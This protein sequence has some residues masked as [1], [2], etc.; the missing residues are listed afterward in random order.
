MEKQLTKEEFQ[1]VDALDAKQ[2]RLFKQFNHLPNNSE[3]AR[4][5]KKWKVAYDEITRILHS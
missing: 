4:L 5:Y 1:T 3:R 2:K